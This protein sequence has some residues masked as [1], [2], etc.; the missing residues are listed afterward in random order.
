MLIIQGK[1]KGTKEV[2]AALNKAPRVFLRFLGAWLRDERARF[3]GGKDS[4]KNTRRGYRDILAGKRLSGRSG[5][6]DA[7][8][9][10]VFKGYIPSRPS[11]IDD[12]M[13]RAGVGLNNPKRIHEA[14]W[15]LQ[16]GGAVSGGGKRMPVPVYGNLAKIGVT[17]GFWGGKAFRR[18]LMDEDRL[19]GV[20]VGSKI[21][22]FDKNQR[23]KNTAGRY[24][25][26]FQRKG[27]LFVGT[28]GIRRAPQF[29]GRYDF[30]ARWGRMVPQMIQRGQGVVD[31]AAK[32]VEGG[33]LE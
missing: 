32:A 3:I 11:R 29:T 14:L 4:K 24:Y 20:R 6:W 13:L 23:Y 33:R 1:T 25:G 10:G 30:Y 16:A 27:L 22:Y 21:F 18:M 17:K 28:Y 9:V 12:L 5:T 31:R 26:G 15:S 7:R 8:V 2:V 19:V